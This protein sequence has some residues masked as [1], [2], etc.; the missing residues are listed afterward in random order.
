VQ[1][2]SCTLFEEL[3][4]QGSQLEQVVTIVEQRLEGPVTEQVIQEY[5]E[6]EALVK[7]QVE[8][9]RAKLEAFKVVFPRSE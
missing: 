2:E 7:Q 6:K 8:A 5:A 4:G 1:D 9:S 3:E